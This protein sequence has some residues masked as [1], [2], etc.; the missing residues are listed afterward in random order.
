MSKDDQEK[1]LIQKIKDHIYF[2]EGMDDSML[3]FYS[4]SATRYVKQKTGTEQEYLVL[5]VASVMNDHR[6]SSED[7][8]K[9]LDALEPI[10]AL[11][12]LTSDSDEQP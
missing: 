5:M 10:F 1:D 3:S 12:V 6:S 7:L 2:E 8:K 11:E 9:A 4:E